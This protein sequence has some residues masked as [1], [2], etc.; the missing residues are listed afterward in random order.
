[1]AF[2][3]KDPSLTYLNKY[4]YNVVKL[5]RTG[6]E[7]LMVLGRDKGLTPIGTL[8][9]V[10]K[11]PG[12]APQ[13]GPPRP[14]SAVEGQRTEKLDLSIGLKLLANA[15]A[16]FGATMPSVDF[17]YHKASKV[18]FNFVHVVTVAIDPFVV[19]DYL[20]TG[21]LN[22]NNPFVQRYLDD[23]DSQAYIITEVLKS[24]SVAVTA[25]DSS[26][27]EIKVDV[28][29]ISGV[30]GA[31]VSVAPSSEGSAQITYKG[32]E[33]VTFGFK[34]FEI[35]Y[36]NGRWT[37]SGVNPDGDLAFAVEPGGGP[38]APMGVVFNAGGLVRL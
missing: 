27:T 4:G 28:P 9:T 12:P 29:A 11:T 8:G 1:V 37:V 18:Q 25:T 33:A 26:G 36:A 24:D 7:P 35:V 21:D 10:W 23:D 34:A 30:V 38:A 22:L 31:N 13:P 16:A 14:A 17:A 19:G 6:I 3:C 5:P 15:L 32:P 20:A 2:G